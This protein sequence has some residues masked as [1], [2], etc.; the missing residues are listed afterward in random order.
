MHDTRCAMLSILFPVLYSFN[1]YKIILH[2]HDLIWFIERERKPHGYEIFTD[3]EKD[4]FNRL[5]SCTNKNSIEKK[6]KTLQLTRG[7]E[8]FLQEF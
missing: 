1:A 7:Y 3:K 8:T 2:N 6:E 5:K 4:T